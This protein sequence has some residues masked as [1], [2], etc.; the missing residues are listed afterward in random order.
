M[1]ERRRLPRTG[2]FRDMVEIRQFLARSDNFA[3]LVHDPRTGAT[4]AIDAPEEGAVQAALDTTGWRLTD[5]L[6]THEHADHVEGIPGLKRRHGCRVVA[7]KLSTKVP[8]ADETVG[9]GD[10]V[11]VGGLAFDVLDTPGHC[12]D[13]IAYWLKAE[14]VVFAG[15]TL[16]A[17]GC[18]RVLGSTP[19]A[20]HASLQKFK[21]MPDDTRVYCGHEYTLSNARFALTVDPGNTALRTRALE[22]ENLRARGYATLPTTIGEEKAT[23]PFLRADDPAVQAAVGMSGADPAA[24]FAELRERKNRA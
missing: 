5:I 13:H 8:E 17:L 2:S 21:A 6:V 18:G 16:F 9:E 19:Q 14:R 12:P 20:L 23:N 11:M 3:V 7:P 10:R 24:V 4:A 1:I 15:D 22:V